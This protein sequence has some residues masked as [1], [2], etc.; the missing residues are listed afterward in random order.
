MRG[1]SAS[2]QL[3]LLRRPLRRSARRSS[4][5]ALGWARPG[6]LLA[7]GCSRRRPLRWLCRSPGARTGSGCAAALAARHHALNFEYALARGRFRR[8]TRGLGA[9]CCGGTG[10]GARLLLRAGTDLAGCC[11]RS[12]R[13]SACSGCLRTL[14]WSRTRTR[15]SSPCRIAVH[16][17]LFSDVAAQVLS[18]GEHEDRTALL[19]ANGVAIARLDD[20]AL[21][22]A[23]PDGKARML[24]RSRCSGGGPLL[25]RSDWPLCSRCWGCARLLSAGLLCRRRL[26]RLLS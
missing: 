2:S 21:N 8:C 12:G 19:R 9:C 16:L 22:H 14:N 17:G 15:S 20:A 11:R 4:C 1:S 10:D 18:A 6:L 24:H 25:R 26:C 3:L 7:G 5:T 23:G 13:S